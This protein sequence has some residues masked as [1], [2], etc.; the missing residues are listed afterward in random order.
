MYF[1]EARVKAF[2][3]KIAEKF[4]R[5]TLLFDILA[6]IAKG[7]SKKHDSLKKIESEA[8]FLWTTKNTKEMEAWNP[9]IHFIHEHFLSDFVPK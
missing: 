5:A 4:E 7:K 3:A 8:E 6:P 1:E 2:F 9:K